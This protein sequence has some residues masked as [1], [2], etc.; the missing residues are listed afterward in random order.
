FADRMR[1]NLHPFFDR[2]AHLGVGKTVLLSGDHAQNVRDVASAIGVQD[3][4]GDL[5]PGDKVAVIQELEAAG[6]HV[7]M[8]GDGTNDAP[9]LS[10]ASVG[11]ALATHGGG[12]TAEAADVVILTND[13]TRV[14]DAVAIGQRSV[15]ILRQSIVVGVG[16]SCVAMIV[17]SFG[18]ITP[19][20]GAALQEVIDVAVILNALRAARD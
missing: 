3:A 13:V 5:L 11:I 6:H 16:L 15:R 9:A 14:A 1:E 20:F 10:A 18:Y 7:L 8:T 12:V 2:L 19:A 4:R 17:A